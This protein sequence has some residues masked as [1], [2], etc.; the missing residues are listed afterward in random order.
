MKKKGENRRKREGKDQSKEQ[1]R[2][3]GGRDKGR[4]GQGQEAGGS[5]TLRV[6]D[7]LIPDIPCKKSQKQKEKKES[8]EKYKG[9]RLDNARGDDLAD[10]ELRRKRSRRS[11]RAVRGLSA[12]IRD[13]K[14]TY[15]SWQRNDTHE[16]LATS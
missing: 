15:D 14:W 7:S 13:P 4:P 12:R 11:L 2:E 9:R 10:E 8:C 1:E 16:N 6:L 3:E 5:G